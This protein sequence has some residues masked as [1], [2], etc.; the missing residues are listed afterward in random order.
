M[1]DF[2]MIAIGLA[3]FATAIAYV[4]GCELLTKKESAK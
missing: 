4:N 1:W 3:F 2:G